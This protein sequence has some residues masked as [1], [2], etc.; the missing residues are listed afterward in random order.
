MTSLTDRYVAATLRGIPE[1]Q[2]PDLER[3]LRSSIADA[4]EDRITNGEDRTAAEVAALE[5]LGDPARLAAGVTGRPLYL[6]GPDLFPGYRY[7]LFL[8]LAIIVPIVGVVQAAVQLGVG[9][10]IGS[11]LLEGIGGALSVGVHLSFWVTLAFVIVERID[12][13]TWEREDF[14]ELKVLK[15]PWKVESLPELPS[16]RA[17]TPGETV[18]EI[19]TIGISIGGLLWL[20]GWSWV[21][22]ASGAPIPLLNPALW[23]AWFPAI[24]A[25]FVLQIGFHVIK[26]AVGRWTMGLAVVNAILLAAIAIPF[27][28]LA[29]S[30]QLINPAFA[31]ATWP[32]L[33]DGDGIVMVAVAVA[34]ILVNGWEAADGF[35]R[36]RRSASQVEYAS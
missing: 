19:V 23:E 18:G 2:R 25:V 28:W 32:A 9:A 8:L 12:P 20:R 29:L 5:E 27:A 16:S 36:A 10:G 14:K 33:D 30:G 22:D 21:T 13:A 35:R 1:K 17:V 24:I 26:L 7:I 11:A 3:E 34:S 6:I 4:V 31:A 15:E